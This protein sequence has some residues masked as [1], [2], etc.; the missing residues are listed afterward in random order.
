MDK[1]ENKNKGYVVFCSKAKHLSSYFEDYQEIEFS[2]KTFSGKEI[3][4][5][6]DKFSDKSF[7]IDDSSEL[8]S[9]LVVQNFISANDDLMELLLTLDLL[10][11]ANAKNVNVLI[12]YF[13]YS[14]Q[15]KI[16]SSISSIGFDVVYK[17]ISS[18]DVENI[19]S[20]D[21]HSSL[22]GVNIINIDTTKIF[23]SHLLNKLIKEHNI[24]I[25]DISIISPDFGSRKRSLGIANFIK[26]E[27]V[28]F[29]EKSRISEVLVK[30]SDN[31][32]KINDSSQENF[33][34]QSLSKPSKICIIVDDIISSGGTINE[35]AKKLR[36]LG[37]EKIFCYCSH[38][39]D[40]S[41]VS[42]NLINIDKIFTSNT[43]YTGCY[44]EFNEIITEDNKLT[45]IEI[46]EIKELCLNIYKSNNQ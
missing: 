6:S 5:F 16:Y 9:V 27:K 1:D 7:I 39:L 19:Y 26:T 36:S 3:L 34:E 24:N 10:K 38:F 22:D 44:S 42:S 32:A 41:V 28:Y 4:I 15:D 17:L 35:C 46:I 23:G 43:C 30:I 25:D 45:N 40:F 18:F 12:P 8:N 11:R 14:R 37:A 20:I 33:S 31:I 2:K 13:A 21:V 29:F